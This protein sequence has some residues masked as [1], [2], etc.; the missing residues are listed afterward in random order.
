MRGLWKGVYWY[1]SLEFTID[2][3]YIGSKSIYALLL[4]YAAST[5][6]TTL[7]CVFF[8]LKSAAQV[9]SA[10]QAMLLS[11][12]IP[13]FLIPFGMAVDMAIRL[14]KIVASAG[15]LKEKTS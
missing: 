14:H 10:Q 6:T 2:I 7:P 13:F 3:L 9:S 5:A 1:I 15:E 4:A 12:Y 11:S 8:I